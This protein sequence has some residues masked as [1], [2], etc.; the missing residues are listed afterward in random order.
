MTQNST[1]PVCACCSGSS[2]AQAGTVVPTRTVPIDGRFEL[3]DH[4]GQPVNE[5]SF[6]ERHLLVFFGFCHCAVV[7]PRELTKLGTAL[8]RLG[9]LAARVQPLYITVDPQRDDPA[10]MQACLARYPGGFLGLTGTPAQI[11]SAKRSYRVFAKPIEDNKAPGGYVVPH[12]ALAY[13]MAPGGRYETHLSDA[14]G[15]DAVAERLRRY[16]TMSGAKSGHRKST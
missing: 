12:T 1:E 11:E 2:A 9:P 3:V 5:R 8:E 15:V 4:F 10:T 14:L 16:I 6:G 7:C 13:L